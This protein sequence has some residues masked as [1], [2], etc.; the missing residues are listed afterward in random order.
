[1]KGITCRRASMLFLGSASVAALTLPAAAIAQDSTPAST[2]ASPEAGVAQ[3]IIV[4]GT[5]ASLNRALDI[6]RNT[7]GIVDS[8]SAEDIGKFPDQNVAESLQHVPGVSIDRSGGE[9]HTIT[10]RGFGPS[11]NETLY[12][13]RRVASANGRA[14]DFSSV[15]ADFVSEVDVLK[16]PDASLSAGAI[17][18]TTSRRLTLAR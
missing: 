6:K 5:R 9:G 1:M 11:F 15:S 14:F 13:G 8:I 12:D 16:S 18:A 3:D 17:G 4:T 10:V 7:I 2:V